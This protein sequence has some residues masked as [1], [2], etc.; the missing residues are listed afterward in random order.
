MEGRT[1]EEEEKKEDRG[2]DPQLS[3]RASLLQEGRNPMIPRCFS[4]FFKLKFSI[5]I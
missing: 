3:Q 2:M 5:S 4:S 1:G